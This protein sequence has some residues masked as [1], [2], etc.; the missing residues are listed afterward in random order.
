MKTCILDA[1]LAR[2]TE[3]AEFSSD[4]AIPMLV[5]WSDLDDQ[6]N[7]TCQR[8]RDDPMM[9]S[10]NDLVST[11]SELQQYR[12]SP[13]DSIHI[14]VEIRSKWRERLGSST[15]LT[16]NTLSLR[17]AVPRSHHGT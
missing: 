5:A 6:V 17:P 9:F 14:V 4:A 7:K 2:L 13:D 11:E 12:Q 8:L 1:C 15:K 16:V 10:G 3:A